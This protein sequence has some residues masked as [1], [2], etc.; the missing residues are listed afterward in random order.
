[1]FALRVALRYL[2]S[3]KGHSAVNV[4]SIVA[5]V[6][7]AVATA[8]II[9]VLSVFNGFTELSMGRL[10][11]IDPPLKV[12]PVSGKVIDRADALAAE[13]ETN[14]QVVAALPSV[15]EQALVM[16]RGRQVPVQLIGLSER[17][18]NF[19]PIDSM[20]IDGEY[21]PETDDAAIGFAA[22][23]LG[24]ASRLGAHP[25]WFD[26][27]ALYAP[28]RKGRI[29]VAA[30]LGAFLSDSMVVSA[31]YEAGDSE[32]DL[33]TAIVP[34]SNARRLFDY[35]NQASAIDVYPVA[36][37][38]V[39]KLKAAISDR[40]GASGVKVLDRL[41]LEE[42]TYRMIAVEKWISFAMLAFILVIASF[43]VISSLSML[44]IEKR[45]NMVT[46]RALGATDAVVRRIFLLEGWLVSMVGAVS[47]VVAGIVL[48]VAQQW[49]GFIK[50][51]GSA[52]NLTITSY[53]VKL[54][55][56]DVLLVLLLSVI[57]GL[58]VGAVATLSVK[59]ARH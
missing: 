16:Y 30:P 24:V 52:A 23:S 7:V 58:A 55:W 36:G 48:T 44:I 12:L 59:S 39:K 53:P 6:G 31:V 1:M 35:S 33:N 26:V 37:A 15:S 19:M 47:G 14:P 2:F 18:R 34:I 43:N 22:L 10:S 17:H 13:I 56:P 9:C 20:V 51:S 11:A 21:S 41:E 3:R 8:A 5:I 54:M 25:G 27:L 50:L 49:G 42:T 46:L 40:F 57:V 29:N 4:I 32:F 28:R 38:N 45:D